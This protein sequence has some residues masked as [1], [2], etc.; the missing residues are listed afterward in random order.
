MESQTNRAHAHPAMTNRTFNAGPDGPEFTDAER[1]AGY[2]P[3]EASMGD[4][5]DAPVVWF[6][7]GEYD[8]TE[9]GDWSAPKDAT[10]AD[11]YRE[12]WES[13]RL[14]GIPSEIGTEAVTP[15]QARA[16]AIA[17]DGAEVLA[18]LCSV[19]VR[20]DAVRK[21]EDAETYTLALGGSALAIPSKLAGVTVFQEQIEALAAVVP[22][23]GFF[24]A[25]IHKGE[26]ALMVLAEL[27]PG[28][29]ASVACVGRIADKHAA[30]I[31]PVLRVNEFNVTSAALPSVGVY[32][33]AVTGGVPGKPTRGVNVVFTGAADAVRLDLRARAREARE[34]AAL[35]SG[36]VVAVEALID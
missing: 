3:W 29:P 15:Y 10:L 4:S 21:V 23:R 2:N 27:E 19:G 17:E 33:S 7:R 6:E 13:V 31:G 28:N 8:A 9:G 22:V 12:G 26:H 16:L 35:D 1:P 18:H 25:K 14:D 36:N 11:A 32:V 20:F 34:A 5:S 30:W 24:P